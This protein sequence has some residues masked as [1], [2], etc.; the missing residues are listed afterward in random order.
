MS[1]KVQSMVYKEATST[2]F[3][4]L[5]KYIGGENEKGIYVLEL[6]KI[7]YSFPFCNKQASQWAHGVI[8]TPQ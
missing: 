4:R 6:V 2:G 8:M 7:L 5:F 3:W 1:T